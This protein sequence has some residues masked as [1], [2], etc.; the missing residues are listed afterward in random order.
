[1]AIKEQYLEEILEKGVL[2]WD[3][4]WLELGSF[5]FHAKLRLAFFSTRE[6]VPIAGMDTT[7]LLVVVEV[8]TMTGL[9]MKLKL[10]YWHIGSLS[11]FLPF[12][13]WSSDLKD[14]LLLGP[15]VVRPFFQTASGIH[16]QVW[17]W[18]RKHPSLSLV[19]TSSVSAASYKYLQ[20]EAQKPDLPGRK[21]IGL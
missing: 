17:L 1:M 2:E 7:L 9:W 20:P 5:N 19:A 15:P 21:T 18:V 11:C 8:T 13:Y 16:W 10:P 3:M 12:S 4:S 14:W 6:I